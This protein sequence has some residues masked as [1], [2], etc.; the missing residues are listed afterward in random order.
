MKRILTTAVLIA[1]LVGL[2]FAMPAIAGAEP[3]ILAFG[4]GD[5]PAIALAGM[6]ITP[7][8][9][10]SLQ[11]GFNAAFLRGLGSVKSTFDL[12]AMRVPSSADTENY[13]WMKELPGMRE[14]IGQRV[15]HNLES[16]VAQLKNKH[17]EHTIGVKRN[18]IEDDK[19]GIYTP[20]LSMQGEIVARHPDELVWGMLPT[21]FA[22]KG[23]D[24]Q[25]FFDTDHV[26]Y[27]AA[28]VEASWSNTGGGA[29]AP[30]FLMDL[31]RSFMKPMIFQERKA[32]E[33]VPM[34]RP[35]SDNVFM[36]GEFLYGADAR[37][38][39]GFGF[40]QLAYGS[41][42]TLDATSFAA[43]RLALETQRRP[44]GSPLAV[45]ATHLVCGP[46]RRT[47][48]EAVLMKEYLASGESNTNYKAVNLVVDPRLG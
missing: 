7:A 37:Y 29:G 2:A 4:N 18:H 42:A 15:V 9:L 24:G 35:D 31:S 45:M 33:F 46:S 3:Q 11:Q 8:T 6:L 38:V 17:Y 23:F 1:G 41:K 26:G 40:H 43:A 21:G 20:M 39:A 32:A 16:S 22:V 47:E 12:V 48:A 34:T 19:L 5:M 13:G 27:T 30:W 25:Y 10:A 36:N 14:W 44:D 28:G